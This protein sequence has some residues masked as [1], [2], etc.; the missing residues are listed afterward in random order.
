MILGGFLQ[1]EVEHQFVS[2]DNLCDLYVGGRGR[3]G[4]LA[5]FFSGTHTADTVP[6]IDHG[7]LFPLSFTIQY[8]LVT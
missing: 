7:M 4:C 5:S 8:C 6:E 3:R 1:D 2:N